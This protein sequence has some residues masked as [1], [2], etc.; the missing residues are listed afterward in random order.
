MVRLRCMIR[1]KQC[2]KPCMQFS[3]YTSFNT[4]TNLKF[5]KYTLNKLQHQFSKKQF[6]LHTSNM[7]SHLEKTNKWV[8]T[9]PLKSLVQGNNS[10]NLRLSRWKGDCI[11]SL[12]VK[13]WLQMCSSVLVVS[14]SSQS[15]SCVLSRSIL[16]HIELKRKL[17]KTKVYLCFEKVYV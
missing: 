16:R 5:K 9:A 3:L 1:I 2:L 15:I 10:S 12:Y 17:T 11:A 14:L 13:R 4:C 6:L 7:K 8:V